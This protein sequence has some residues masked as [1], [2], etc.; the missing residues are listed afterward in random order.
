[1]LN[2]TMACKS[3]N[4][5]GYV[6]FAGTEKAC[7]RPCDCMTPCP[8]C[9]DSGYVLKDSD[10]EAATM[11]PCECRVLRRRIALFNAAGLPAAMHDRTLESF[12]VPRNAPGNLNDVH[13]H[14]KRYRTSY[15]A[16]AVKGL[17]LSGPPGT[18]KTHLICALLRH[19][20][21]EMGIAA[22]FIDFFHLL[23]ILRSS[24]S[25]SCSEE[26][27]LGPL[28]E[29]EVLAI[30]ELGKGRATD[31]EVSVVD[32]LVSR[33]Y[34]TGRTVLATTNYEME[35]APSGPG[36]RGNSR[37]ALS[38]R[39]GERVF[40]RLVEMCQFTSVKGPDYRKRNNK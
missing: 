20:T 24:Y 33:R 36:D 40:S 35:S 14:L 9:G 39:V 18:G 26:E 12:K 5:T 19:F 25:E 13:V 37:T 38:E 23:S 15:S 21:L 6:T 31:W 7:A 22:R 8:V 34:N 3:C 29:V 2:E 16:P 1:M 30:D 17:L 10:D 11:S 32:Q 27:I 4:K 28:V